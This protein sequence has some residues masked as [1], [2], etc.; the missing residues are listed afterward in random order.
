MT[1][2]PTSLFLSVIRFARMTDSE[3]GGRASTPP[4]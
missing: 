3:Q 2:I 1:D 4:S